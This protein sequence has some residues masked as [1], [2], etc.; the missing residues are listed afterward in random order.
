MSNEMSNEKRGQ[1]EAR[2]RYEPPC[3]KQW[4]NVNDVTKVGETN[5]GGDMNFGSVNPPGHDS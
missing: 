4:G 3:L 1:Q 5:P 2:S